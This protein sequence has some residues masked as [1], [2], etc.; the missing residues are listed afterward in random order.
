MSILHVLS[1]SNDRESRVDVR[2]GTR[3]TY[4]SN[5]VKSRSACLEDHHETLT[6]PHSNNHKVLAL[7]LDATLRIKAHRWVRARTAH[8]CL[9]GEAVGGPHQ[10]PL[11]D[12]RPQ[13]KGQAPLSVNTSIFSTK[14]AIRTIESWHPHHICYVSVQRENTNNESENGKPTISLNLELFL[15]WK[16]ELLE[17]RRRYTDKGQNSKKKKETRW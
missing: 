6:R 9:R 11:C 7:C 4:K 1:F 16:F 2:H 17:P 3:N 14:G 15:L 10:D 13:P 8:R 5:A 12:K